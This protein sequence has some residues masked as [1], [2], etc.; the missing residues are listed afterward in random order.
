[1]LIVKV[2]YEERWI[3]RRQIEIDEA[4]LDEWRDGA[5]VTPS[6]LKEFLEAEPDAVSGWMNQPVHGV[7]TRDFDE[8][9]IIEVQ[10]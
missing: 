7:P 3:C 6:L 10:P 8:A 4:E 9:E 1:V 2:I 5:A